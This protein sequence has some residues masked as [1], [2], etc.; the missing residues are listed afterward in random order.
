M[1]E[2]QGPDAGFK[3]PD[4]AGAMLYHS[5]PARCLEQSHPWRQK[6]AGGCR[7]AGERERGLGV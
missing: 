7:G 2:P 4:V 6:V 5:A 3:E 1:D